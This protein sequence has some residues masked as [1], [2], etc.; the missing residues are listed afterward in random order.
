MQEDTKTVIKAVALTGIAFAASVALA[1]P[2]HAATAHEQ[3]MSYILA[4]QDKPQKAGDYL[5]TEKDENGRFPQLLETTAYCQGSHG[6][7]GDK[8]RHG[9]VAYTPES[10]G[11][12]I[13]LYK[14]EKTE[15]GYKLGEY[16]GLF[17]VRDTGFGHETGQGRSSI[18][19]DKKSKGSIEIGKTIDVFHPTY[20]ECVTW[21]KE[22]EGMVFAVIIPNVKG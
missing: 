21:M 17:E 18:R 15:D 20:S 7:R 19:P 1:F 5:Y 13:D 22:T 2:T 6:S 12:A 11:C 10:Y 9:Y 4:D 16:L 14:A 8:M 3:A